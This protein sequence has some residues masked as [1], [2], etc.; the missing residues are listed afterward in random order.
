MGEG[1][2]ND[3]WLWEACR[4]SAHEA[5]RFAGQLGKVA[6]GC[7]P[8]HDN[9]ATASSGMLDVDSEP[10]EEEAEEAEAPEQASE[11]LVGGHALLEV[12][13][14]AAGQPIILFCC[15]CGAYGQ[16]MARGLLAPCSPGKPG[17]SKQLKRL[18]DGLHPCLTRG[19]AKL[20]E[21]RAPSLATREE[22][23]K[24]LC[25]A[26]EP[27]RPEKPY[28]LAPAAKPSRSQV[29]AA[30]G[31]ATEYEAVEVAKQAYAAWRGGKPLGT[32]DEYLHEMHAEQGEERACDSSDSDC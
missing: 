1:D 32:A 20:G 3:K 4:L 23:C 31:Y 26:G 16:A 27:A 21:P 11:W 24:R 22:W 18:G 5:C 7:A 30:Y 2:P 19:K 8:D 25:V 29:L 12:E 6:A 17:A 28:G 13:E 9:V 15:R 10:N 14:A